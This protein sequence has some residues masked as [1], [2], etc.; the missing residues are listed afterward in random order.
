MGF[1]DAVTQLNEIKKAGLIEDYAIGG[2]YAVN[3]YDVPQGTYDLDVFIIIREKKDF[4]DLCELYEHFRKEGARIEKEYVFVGDLPV[5]FLAN[6][7]P[8]YD[9]AVKNA[10]TVD[11]HGVEARFVDIEHLIV[12]LLT[13]FRPKDRLR[14]KGLLNKADAAK[15]RELIER[16]GNAENA[17]SQRYRAVLGRTD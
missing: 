13:S 2:A 17:L 6:I 10:M 1:K 9:D 8:L 5:Q 12:M 14:I 4:V 11:F 16:F 15:L 7:G 3:L